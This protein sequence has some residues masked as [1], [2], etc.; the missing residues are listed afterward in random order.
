MVYVTRN[1]AQGILDTGIREVLQD[2]KVFAV[3]STVDVESED[4]EPRT[5]AA[6][7]ISLL[8]TLKQT[9]QLMLASE[10]GRVRLVMRSPED[11]ETVPGE[12]LGFADVFGDRSGVGNRSAENPILT[13]EGTTTDKQGGSFLETLENQAKLA[14]GA[15]QSAAEI[16][17]DTT[18]R[19]MRIVK[20]GVVED[21]VL[22]MEE[23]RLAANPGSQRWRVTEAQFG[24]DYR[25]PPEPV[26]ETPSEPSVEPEAEETESSDEEKPSE[27]EN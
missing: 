12:M 7:T 20:G 24:A 8:V 18:R 16:E 10:L 15:S 27:D 4:S 5:M 25:P 11:D 2:I 23:D 1:P 9:K 6:K 13:D 21:V 14:M 17:G 3:D 22:E 26:A 19:T